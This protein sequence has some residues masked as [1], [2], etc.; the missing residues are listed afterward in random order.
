MK[1]QGCKFIHFCDNLRGV[2]LARADAA[3]REEDLRTFEKLI[4]VAQRL[5]IPTMR[6]NTGNP[7]NKDYDFNETIKAYKRL[8]GY[9]KD[10]GVEIII[11]NHFGLSADPQNVV[12]ILEAVGGNVSA[13][14][15]F[16]LLPKGEERWPMLEQMCKHSK[17]VCSAKFHGLDD[18]GKHTD[19]DLKRSYDILLAA[20]FPGWVSLEY[21]GPYEPM[22]QLERMLP[23]AKQWLGYV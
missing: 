11:E 16:G 15:D 8:A 22:P 17:R 3:K 18:A 14:P 12:R 21:E 20:G 2:N 10:R 13:C 9:G 5:R 23:L 7:E 6:V 1:D 4:D 19:F